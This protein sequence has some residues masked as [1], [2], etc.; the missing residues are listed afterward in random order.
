MTV[1]LARE[2]TYQGKVEQ[3]SWMTTQYSSAER[4]CQ[5]LPKGRTASIG[6]AADIA[7]KT[8]GEEIVTARRKAAGGI[9]RALRVTGGRKKEGEG[10]LV[11]TVGL[12]PILMTKATGGR[13]IV[14]KSE[15]SILEETKDNSLLISM[16]L[17]RMS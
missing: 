9:E 4:P 3:K 17:M 6:E 1:R 11:E 8:E 10:N 13:R 12:E 16:T 14:T 15:G 5:R 7:T 2:T